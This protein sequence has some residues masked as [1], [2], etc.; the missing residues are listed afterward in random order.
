MA[1]NVYSDPKVIYSFE[2]LDDGTIK[3][4]KS[5][6][7]NANILSRINFIYDPDEGFSGNSS[8]YINRLKTIQ[9]EIKY[10]TDYYPVKRVNLGYTDV[11]A[12]TH[13]D[14]SYLRVY[15]HNNIENDLFINYKRLTG[16][17]YEFILDP[18]SGGS[19]VIPESKTIN[20][21]ID[22][23]KYEFTNEINSV[24]DYEGDGVGKEVGSIYSYWENSMG[25][26]FDESYRYWVIYPRIT[27][28]DI[29]ANGVNLDGYSIKLLSSITIDEKDK[30]SKY[31][32]DSF[33]KSK[34]EITIYGE[35]IY[36]Y[37]VKQVCRI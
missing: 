7:I 12:I 3:Y 35:S 33:R 5:Y 31:Y 20:Y 17:D 32:F 6:D 1:D 24:L 28:Y 8:I 4:L 30:V 11:V 37:C 2:Y 15:S 9:K 22:G 29:R 25:Y 19:D 36:N 16:I 27:H 21:D 23:K 14:S 18:I 34:D 10:G 26:I 13:S